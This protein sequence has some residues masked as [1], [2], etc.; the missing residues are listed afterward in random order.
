MLYSFQAQFLLHILERVGL[1]SL[2]LIAPILWHNYASDM[3]G[4]S[5]DSNWTSESDLGSNQKLTLRVGPQLT[6]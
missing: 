6:R 3:R 1:T 5:I 2:P 4:Q